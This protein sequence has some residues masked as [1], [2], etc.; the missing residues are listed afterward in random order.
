[1]YINHFLKAWLPPA[2][3]QF[4]VYWVKLKIAWFPLS[5]NIITYVLFQRKSHSNAGSR[6]QVQKQSFANAMKNIFLKFRN[7]HSKTSVLES[8]F[9]KV[10]ELHA[11]NFIKVT[12]TQ[13]FSCEYCKIF[14][15]SFF[16]EHVQWLVL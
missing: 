6:S 14:K 2:S 8:V 4:L 9:I 7:I 15:N 5:H 16:I 13:L 3:I 11:C 10:A 1:M 12:S